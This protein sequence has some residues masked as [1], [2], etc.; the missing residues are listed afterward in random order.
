MKTTRFE[1][2]IG[3]KP[4]RLRVPGRG[5]IT[6]RSLALT[7]LAL[8][9]LTIDGCASLGCKSCGDHRWN[10][11]GRKR[12]AVVGALIEP[13]PP[14][15]IDQ[16]GPGTVVTPGS[17]A[18][19]GGD[20]EDNPML[21]PLNSKSGSSSSGGGSGASTGGSNGASN[22]NKDHALNTRALRS[23][24]RRTAS[25]TRT[26]TQ[27]RTLPRN[28]PATGPARR[29][30]LAAADALL[31]DLPAPATEIGGDISPPP[32]PEADRTLAGATKSE[33]KPNSNAA[34][35]RAVGAVGA[36]PVPTPADTATIG[37]APGIKRFKAVDLKLAAGSFPN[38][39]GL[40][41]LAEKGYRTVLDLREPA[42]VRSGDVAAVNHQALRYVALPVSE[43]SLSVETFK[44]FEAEL[45]QS[46]A[47]P[48]LLFRR[49]RRASGGSLVR[50]AN[51]GRSRRRGRRASRS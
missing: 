24:P 38:G 33:L 26:L 48:A 15:V 44:R 17:G 5:W 35:T 40:A 30:D 2:A 10:L 49:R 23:T 14:M 3:S 34:G 50:Q 12:A 39:D 19:T 20:A 47:R 29:N 11:F 25:G 31:N 36:A 32:S 28:E 45:A 22:S 4:E 51:R 42:E 7:A 41:W 13:G 9:T 27:S 6:G 1:A 37:A 46:G 43:S 21:A 16:S 8:L 18:A